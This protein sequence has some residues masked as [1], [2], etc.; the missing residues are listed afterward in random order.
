MSDAA[1]DAKKDQMEAI[2]AE[3]VAMREMFVESLILCAVSPRKYRIRYGDIGPVS[4]VVHRDKRWGKYTTSE[5]TQKKLAQRDPQEISRLLVDLI[6]VYGI[7]SQQ[8]CAV[9]A[10]VPSI[11]AQT[12]NSVDQTMLAS[13]IQS[14]TIHR[15]KRQFL[16]R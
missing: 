3:N 13:N 10:V 12:I 2:L 9:K 1:S 4:W 7:A 14:E 5:S 11:V 6:E 16:A 8:Y 15:L